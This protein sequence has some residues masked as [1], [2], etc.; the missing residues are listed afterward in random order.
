MHIPQALV[1]ICWLLVLA[2]DAA[3]ISLFV[4]GTLVRHSVPL[5]LQVKTRRY[6]M[7]ALYAVCLVA[8]FAVMLVLN[9]QNLSLLY[10]M[11]TALLRARGLA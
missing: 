8:G 10:G 11:A 7:A 4:M 6:K 9:L 5:A 2:I 3:A 1:Q